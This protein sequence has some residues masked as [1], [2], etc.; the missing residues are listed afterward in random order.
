MLPRGSTGI[1]TRKCLRRDLVELEAWRVKGS[2]SPHLINSFAKSHNVSEITP[3]LY[4]LVLLWKWDVVWWLRVL[5]RG[6]RC[7]FEGLSTNEDDLSDNQ[8][9]S[10]FLLRGFIYRDKDL[11]LRLPSWLSV[12]C[13]NQNGMLEEA[14]SSFCCWLTSQSSHANFGHEWVNLSGWFDHVHWLYFAP[15]CS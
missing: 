5:R 4:G 8:M 13:R 6:V 3:Y 10:R 9:Y 7:M 12:Q 1:S 2:H 11:L 14:L 15:W